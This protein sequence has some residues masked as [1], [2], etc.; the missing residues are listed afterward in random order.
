MTSSYFD[1]TLDAI[2]ENSDLWKKLDQ[3]LGLKSTRYLSLD[4]FDTFFRR[5]CNEPS[6]VFEETARR[7]IKQQIPLPME[8]LDYRQCRIEAEKCARELATAEDVTFEAIFD[9]VPLS[10]FLKNALMREELQVEAEILS[11]DPLIR[12]II[13]KTLSLGKEV[14][15][16]SDMY[17]S[18]REIN[19]L[20]TSKY[21]GLVFRKLF[22]SSDVGLTKLSGGMFRY[23]VDTLNTQPECIV[24]IGDDYYADFLSAKQ[25]GLNSIHFDVPGY[26]SEILEKER[27]YQVQLPSSVMHARKL[28]SLSVPSNLPSD[29]LFFFYYGAFILGPLLVSFSKWVLERSDNLGIRCI[30]ALMREGGIISSCIN[31]ELNTKASKNHVYCV[32]CYASRKATFLPALDPSGIADGLGMILMRKNY[33]VRDIFTEFELNDVRLTPYL[34]MPINMLSNVYIDGIDIL[35]FIKIIMDENKREL[36]ELISNKKRLLRKYI[37]NLTNGKPFATIDFGGGATIQHQLSKGLEKKANINFLVYTTA[38]GYGKSTEVNLNSFI[39]Y[40]AE[41]K[42]GINLITRSPEILE[43]LLVGREQTT[44]SYAENCEGAVV[45]LKEEGT[46]TSKHLQIID[47]FEQGV[48]TFQKWAQNLSVTTPNLKDRVA[49]LKILERLIDC[50]EK[51]EVAFLGDL[52]H[53]DNFGSNRSYKIINSESLNKLKREGISDTY[54]QFSRN[55]SYALSWLSW[56]QGSIT[57]LDPEFMKDL[58]QL[59]TAGDKHLDAVDTLGNLLELNKIKNVIVYGAGEFFLCLLPI[60]NKLN[61]TISSLIDKKAKFGSYNVAGY[62]VISL[63]D[64]TLKEG[65]VVLVASAAYI[66]EIRRDIFMSTGNS[67]ITVISL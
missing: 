23:V 35:T 27:R 42:K 2:L 62:A 37:N 56:P 16:I 49:Y 60:I 26:M 18:H 7:L 17:L 29:C 3:L 1:M 36:C 10:P 53:E 63:S 19:I 9:C 61:I 50:P 48:A 67:N 11:V 24:H 20:I 45:P 58:L 12:R 28:A 47:A 66:E 65:D 5:S 52:T 39:P 51:D 13:E 32:P 8:P 31:N 33:T 14:I 57:S 34:D 40:E 22:V 41:T 64:C 54:R 15:F 43:I 38:R 30:L 46:Y 44:I 21:P 59:R 25:N 55:T 6:W 4:I